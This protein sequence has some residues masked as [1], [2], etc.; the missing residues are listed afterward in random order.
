M[1]GDR[2]THAVGV[3]F[4]E[5]IRANQSA[6]HLAGDADERNRVQLG[7]GDG[8]QDVGRTRARG[9][10]THGRFAAGARQ[11][12]RNESAPCSWRAST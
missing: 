12:L 7:I 8:R 3:D 9:G 2:D 5:G 6:R 1:F 10:E 11:P 4:L